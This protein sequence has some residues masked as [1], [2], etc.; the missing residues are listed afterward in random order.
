MDNETKL[1][2]QKSV[3]DW[4]L[5]NTDLIQQLEQPKQ[6]SVA[7]NTLFDELNQLGLLSIF[8]DEETRS[9]IS[10]L[11][12]VGC[13]F[14]IHSA[15]IALM[16]VQQNLAC[17][18]LAQAKLEAPLGWVALPLYDS[19]Y[20]W[21]Y[22]IQYEQK[23]KNTIT[24]GNWLSISLLPIATT[25]LLPIQ[26]K[27]KTTSFAHISLSATATKKNNIEISPAITA[28]GLR[29][30]P[31]GDLK[32]NGLSLSEDDL[33]LNSTKDEDFV[34]NLW[35]QAEIYIMAIRSGIAESSYRTARDY[36]TERYQGGK[37][38]IEHSVIRKMLADFYREKSALEENW[39]TFSQTISPDLSISDGL[40]G[41]ALASA[42][43]LPWLTSDGI[44]ILGGVGYMS[45]FI[46][47]RRFRDAKQCEFLLG[48]PQAKAFSNWHADAS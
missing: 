27:D 33:I 28:L 13:Q 9:E 15:S 4:C 3:N 31:S 10:M 47:E 22:Q 16:V 24:N 48:H 26:A 39:R 2:L 46:Q 45:D 43:K 41:I 14:A 19:V 34:T 38:I 35:S 7:A 25:L 5:D 8:H 17:A 23:G 37:I 29:G 30:A 18:L 6:N 32:A 12:E 36:A 42:E 44:Q 40:M 11:A 21:S 1:I 20:E